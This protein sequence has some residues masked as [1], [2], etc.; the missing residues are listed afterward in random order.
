MPRVTFFEIRGPR[1][2]LALCRQV[3]AAYEA[4]ERVCVWAESEAEARRLDDLLWT[5][6][7]ESFVPHDLW[8]GETALDTPVAVGWRPGNPNGAACLVLARGAAPAE[9]AGF[10]RVVDFAPVDL[11]D[12]LEPAR[13]RF[14]AF[15]AAGFEVEFCK[16]SP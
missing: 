16:G 8:Q 12:R 15:R 4:G 7:D 11:P 9:A 13:A 5:F 6:R 2:D 14:R 1:W 3:E 10:G